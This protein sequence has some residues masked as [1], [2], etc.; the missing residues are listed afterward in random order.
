MLVL[1]RKLGETITIDGTIKV[2]VLGVS[3]NRVRLGIAAPDDCRISR[4]ERYAEKPA[5]SKPVAAT[6]LA[7]SGI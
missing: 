1:K 2:E 7:G 3:G 4:A 6:A 5:G